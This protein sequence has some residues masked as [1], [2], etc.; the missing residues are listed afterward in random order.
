MLFAN[1]DDGDYRVRAEAEGQAQT[2]TVSLKNG[3]A[4]ELVYRFPEK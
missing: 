2:K 1:M 4:R 3:E